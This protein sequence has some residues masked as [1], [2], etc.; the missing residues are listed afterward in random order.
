MVLEPM[1]KKLFVFAGQR[2]DTYLSDMYTYDIHSNSVARVEVDS[3][4]TN[5]PSC[6]TQRAVIDSTL[7]EIYV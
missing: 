2:E 3:S 5:L 6:F 1:T 4:L 7:R